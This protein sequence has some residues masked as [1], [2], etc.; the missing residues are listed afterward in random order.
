VKI[1]LSLTFIFLFSS[2]G[3]IEARD[4]D[5]DGIY[6]NENSRLYKKIIGKKMEAYQ[7]SNSQLIDRGIIFAGWVNGYEIVYIKELSGLNI[8]Y[9]YHTRK[10]RRREVWRLSGT[11][12]VMKLSHNGRYLFLKRILKENRVPK[13]ETVFLNLKSK[14]NGILGTDYPFLDFSVTPGGNSLLYEG[15]KGIIELF[16]ESG[17]KKLIINKALYSDITNPVL[18]TIAV[19]SPNRM[20]LLIFNGSGGLYRSKVIVNKKSWNLKGITSSSEIFWIDNHRI[21]YRIGGA[22]SFSAVLYDTRRKRIKRLV[23][24]SLNTN[25]CYSGYPRIVSFLKEQVIIFFSIRENK[26]FNSGIEGEDAYFSPDGSRFVSLL[27]KRLFVTNLH[28]LKKRKMKIKRVGGQIL[29][30]YAELLK[31]RTDLKNEY[32]VTYLKRKIALYKEIAK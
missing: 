5:L 32:S 1:L 22:G 17:I 6:I 21:I 4:V 15:K 28:M 20:K 30:L 7:A 25:I 11:V 19:L 24:N 26:F 23:K 12:T 16:P 14:K 2:I 31:N 9:I 10:Y 27:H 29:K 8:V 3:F 13:G 18:P